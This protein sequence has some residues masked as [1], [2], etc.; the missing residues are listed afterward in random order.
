M[1]S[2]PQVN[3]VAESIGRWASLST[4]GA[5]PTG[6]YFDVS[7]PNVAFINVQHPSSG[8]DRT[9]QITAVPEVGAV[10]AMLF[11]LGLIGAVVRRHNGRVILSRPAAE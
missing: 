5:E 9:I 2:T 1:K 11:G 6:L 3:G 8:V 10:W 7:D 4:L